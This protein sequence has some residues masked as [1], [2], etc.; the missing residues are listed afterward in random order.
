MYVV[1]IKSILQEK[2]KSYSKLL[3]LPEVSGV[4][5]LHPVEE[6]GE[7]GDFGEMELV[8]DLGDAQRGLVQEEGGFHQQ[9]LVD[10]INDGAA[11]RHLTDDAREIGGGD[12]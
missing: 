6:A 9:Q 8:G 2:H 7:G 1:S 5:A 3:P 4:H 11:A 12:A 10:V